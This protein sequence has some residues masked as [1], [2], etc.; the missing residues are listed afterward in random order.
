MKKISS[1][2]VKFLCDTGISHESCTYRN[3][4][5]KT[6]KY[7]HMN[8]K[9]KGDLIENPQI[10]T[11]DEVTYSHMNRKRKGDLIENPQILAVEAG[12]VKE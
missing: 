4:F 10:L 6:S 9:R 1:I 2:F 12:L 7:S 3:L 5:K 11:Y 8:R